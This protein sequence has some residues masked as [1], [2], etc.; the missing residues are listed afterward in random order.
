M[1]STKEAAITTC[2]ESFKPSAG[3]ALPC[4]AMATSR[5]NDFRPEEYSK[6]SFSRKHKNLF[7][8]TL[9]KTWTN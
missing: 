8:S 2:E 5:R 6:S 1:N 9:H 3:Q 7:T 4:K